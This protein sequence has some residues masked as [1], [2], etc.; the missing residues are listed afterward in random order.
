MRRK[1]M[2]SKTAGPPKDFAEFLSSIGI[3]KRSLQRVKFGG[4][5]GK[6]ALVGVA[7]LIPLAV[8]AWKSEGSI[9]L[10]WGCLTVLFLI[11]FSTVFAIGFHGHQHPEQA[12]LE[13]AEIVM[14]Q[15]LQNVVSAKGAGE[16]P[17]SGT[18]MEGSV[19][20]QAIQHSTE[21]KSGN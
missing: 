6:Q 2:A 11:C 5:V 20:D 13:G 1:P 21:G 16:I 4:V 8:I 18:I 9:S 7:A 12:T 17:V 15:H 3:S 10:L 19:G 14:L